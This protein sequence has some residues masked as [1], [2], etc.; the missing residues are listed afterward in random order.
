MF[1][2]CSSKG[3]RAIAVILLYGK[4]WKGMNGRAYLSCSCVYPCWFNVDFICW[5][6]AHMGHMGHTGHIQRHL[7][8]QPAP[9][10]HHS[11]IRIHE[12]GEGSQ[13]GQVVSLGTG[14]VDPSMQLL[15]LLPLSKLLLCQ[16]DKMCTFPPFLV[17]TILCKFAHVGT[18]SQDLAVF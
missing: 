1:Q 18:C 10:G 15:Q 8:P 14:R 4:G 2:F 12:L 16:L 11:V 7:H 9:G 6:M 5:G 3:Q 13:C 17:C